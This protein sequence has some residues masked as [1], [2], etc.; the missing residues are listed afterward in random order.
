[1]DGFCNWTKNYTR[2]LFFIK[3]HLWSMRILEFRNILYKT[4][5]SFKVELKGT[6]WF[7]VKMAE[8]QDD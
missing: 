6:G 2:L 7:K 1:M 3:P 5:L 8:I 4:L